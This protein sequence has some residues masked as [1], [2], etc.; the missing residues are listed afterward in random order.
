CGF[1]DADTD[2][3]D[4][5]APSYVKNGNRR[6]F[7]TDPTYATPKLSVAKT[8]VDTLLLDPANASVRFGLEILNGTSIPSDY[9]NTTQVSN[10][11]NDKSVLKAVVGTDHT[12]LKT[13]VDGLVATSGTPLANR[14]IVAARYFKHDGYFT[15]ADP[16]QYTCQRNFLVIMTDGRPQAEGNTAFGSCGAGFTDPLCG[17]NA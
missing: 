3:Q 10:Y 14:T 7:E 2:G 12:S 15:T 16:I 5:R 11:H 8:V 9:T 17:A 13:I 6:N 4:D 1:V